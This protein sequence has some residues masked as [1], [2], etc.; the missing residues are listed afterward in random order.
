MEYG[1]G[2]DIYSLLEHFG[3]FDEYTAKFYIAEAILAIEYIHSEG[4]VH[5]DVK[6]DNLLL[7]SNGHIKLTDFGL[8][9]INKKT[10]ANGDFSITK[11]KSPA[12]PSFVSHFKKKIEKKLFS[13]VGTP[14]YVSPE[15][16]AGNGYGYCVDWW[17]LGAVLFEMLA[18]IP[19]FN[20]ETV[21][22]TIDNIKRNNLV[23]W[24]RSELLSENAQDLV[25]KLLER[26]P[27]KRIGFHGA[28]EI[29]LHS[30][31]HGFD[32]KD[33]Q[34][35][36]PPFMPK[37][38]NPESTFYFKGSMPFV[39][40]QPQPH[41]R[42]EEENLDESFKGFSFVNKSNLMKLNEEIAK[43]RSREKSSCTNMYHCTCNI[44][45]PINQM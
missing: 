45:C 13:G 17:A 39:G 26:D 30:F 44:H 24:P 32:W 36:N 22:H 7:S 10:M 31:F 40:K 15:V 41:L 27:E 18:G 14:D 29:K 23:N 21:R 16:L 42:I 28:N 8:S 34:K 9:S 43:Q 6:P 2:G 33:I 1:S 35:R 20:G 38:D 37:L 3:Y 19:P 11:G 5:R 12:S 25:K 4:I